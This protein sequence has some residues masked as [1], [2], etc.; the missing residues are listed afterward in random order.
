MA[1]IGRLL[2]AMARVR[3]SSSSRIGRWICRSAREERTE[4]VRS[5]SPG[6]SA[7]AL[8]PDDTFI[9]GGNPGR[10]PGSRLDPGRG[11]PDLPSPVRWARGPRPSLWR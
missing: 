1:V 2:E 11:L 7:G 6:V 9:S 5:A 8:Y 10:H 3:S 4:R